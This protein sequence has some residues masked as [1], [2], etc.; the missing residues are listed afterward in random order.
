MK[1]QTRESVQ[2]YTTLTTSCRPSAGVV[3]YGRCFAAAVLCLLCVALVSGCSSTRISE[4]ENFVQGKLPRPN[5]ILVYDFAATPADVPADSTLAK[6]YSVVAASETPEQ[7]AMGH[8]L[9]AQI[10]AQLIKEIHDMGMPARHAVT[11]AVPDINDLVIRGYLI[12]VKPGSAGKRVAIGLG[13][14]ESNLK[15]AVEGLQMTAHGLRKLASGAVESGGSKTPGA[16]AGAATFAA[17][18]NPLGLIVVGGMR[19]Y[20]EVSGSSKIE[21]R[22]K[23]ISDEIA[24]ALRKRFQEQGWID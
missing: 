20:G 24:N 13:A 7:I 23:Q 9:G 3:R 21:A 12:S 5:Q 8:R 22:A 6:K 4:R 11:G 17:T 15:V 14:G 2:R 10:S 16:A 18:A 19:L 1:H